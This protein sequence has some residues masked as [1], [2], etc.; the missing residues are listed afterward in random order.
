MNSG[1]TPNPYYLGK[2]SLSTHLVDAYTQDCLNP[3]SISITVLY[4]PLAFGGGN[5]LPK[6][7]FYVRNQAEALEAIGR[8][9]LNF[10]ITLI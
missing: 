4:C 6:I 3:H 2:S 9:V 1:E 7:D 8:R 10:N 5:D